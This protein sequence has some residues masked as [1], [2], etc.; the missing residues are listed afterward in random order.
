MKTSKI[1]LAIAAST[2]LFA[3]CAKQK[4]PAD[5]ALERIETSLKAI[6]DDAAKY[7]PEGL[8]SVEAQYDS[9][10]ASYEKK[11]YEQVLAGTP[12]LEK[13]VGS[14]GD[15][16]TS[17]KEHAVAARDAAKAEWE[18]LSTSVPMMVDNIEK[19]VDAL[20]K[21]KFMTKGKKAELESAKT[22]LATM[23]S[24]W[25]EASEDF[26]SGNPINA[27]TKGKQAKGMGDELYDRLDIK[28]A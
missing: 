18:M 27:T 16:V 11:D 20:S 22:T 28:K 19:R 17:G 5:H 21:K 15:A 25:A 13:A 8:K 10:K 1:L 6:K 4:A 12:Q 7:A 14:L 2:L 9:L 3:G 26:K 23:K 24:M